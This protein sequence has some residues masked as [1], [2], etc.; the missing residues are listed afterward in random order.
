MKRI[1]Y[2]N[3]MPLNAALYAAHKIDCELDTNKI[4]EILL[5]YT[6]YRGGL[7][8]NNG[9]PYFQFTQLLEAF[10]EAH[11]MISDIIELAHKN[12]SHDD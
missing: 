6:L 10:V 11:N 12:D 5:L 9:I 4:D 1:Y 3:E 2:S 8:D 7:I